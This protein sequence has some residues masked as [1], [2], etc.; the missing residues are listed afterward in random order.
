[1]FPFGNCL[2]EYGSWKSVRSV[3]CSTHSLLARENGRGKRSRPCCR[4]LMIITAMII[5]TAIDLGQTL[6]WALSHSVHTTTTKFNIIPI[7]QSVKGRCRGFTQVGTSRRPCWNSPRS[8]G[9]QGLG[10]HKPE[11]SG[12][13]PWSKGAGEIGH[14]S[15]HIECVCSICCPVSGIPHWSWFHS[16]KFHE[17]LKW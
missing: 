9:H 2:K 5:P 4:C 16:Q 6:C 1:M 7:L 8:A 15:F 11:C 13:T 3:C 10:L 14:L 12:Y 17:P